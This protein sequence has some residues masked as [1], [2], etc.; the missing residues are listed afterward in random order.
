LSRNGAR[1]KV[2]DP[3]ANHEAEAD[4]RS[5]INVGADLGDA[6]KAA[7]ALFIATDWPQFV[8]LDFKK[9]KKMMRGNLIVDCMNAIDEKKVASAGLTYIGVGRY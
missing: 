2:Y 5:G 8:G 6:I 1:V 3:K 4:L 7:D 9:V